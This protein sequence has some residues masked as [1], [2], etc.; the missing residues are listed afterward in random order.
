MSFSI[1]TDTSA[2]IPIEMAKAEDI[3]IM[4][5]ICHIEGTD[6]AQSYADEESMSSKEF[7]DAMRAGARVK[8]S[9]VNPQS[10]VDKMEPL[11]R[12]GKDILFVGISSGVSG[13]FASAQM[14]ANMLRED[15]PQRRIRLI[16]SLGASLGEGLLVVEAIRRRAEGQDLDEVADYLQDMLVRMY[17]VF[18]VDD[19]NYLARGG[20]LSNI[21]ALAGMVLNIKPLLKGNENGNIVSF[22]KVRGRK[23]IIELLAQKYEELVVEPEKQTIGM[24]HADCIEDAQKLIELINRNKPPKEII[25]VDHEPSTG[26]YLGP[27]ALAI[28][29][30]GD[31]D[32]R[33]K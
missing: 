3:T 7:Y 8:T 26:S 21:T 4:P 33:Y 5:I 32:V 14:A 27:G 1:I 15:Y 19:L 24:S 6:R 28:Y 30:L 13:T 2:N 17:Q 29:F 25:L 9:Q 20:R 11:L 16:D 10:Y 18:T 12:D 23:K 31:R 22:G